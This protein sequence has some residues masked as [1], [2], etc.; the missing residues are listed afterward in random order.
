M[1]GQQS[2]QILWLKCRQIKE[3][4]SCLMNVYTKICVTYM[5][6]SSHTLY[7]I[8]ASWLLWFSL[9]F[10]LSDKISSLVRK[11][12]VSYYLLQNYQI[13]KPRPMLTCLPYFMP[14]SSD[15]QYLNVLMLDL[16]FFILMQC[17]V[18]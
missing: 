11:A 4:F 2:L 14:C 6:Y 1:S 16:L 12:I 18:R 7:F 8:S 5:C 15:D 3:R 13:P 9:C 10:L 17:C